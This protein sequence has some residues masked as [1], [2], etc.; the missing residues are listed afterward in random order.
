MRRY[1]VHTI[2]VAILYVLVNTMTVY[3]ACAWVLWWD[4][5]TSSNSYRTADARVPGGNIDIKKA[6]S[7]NILDTFTTETE[8]RSSLTSKIDG[9]LKNW[10]KE[11]A[12]AKAGT[13]TIDQ[14]GSNIIRKRSEY[15]GEHTSTHS[16]SLRYLCMPDTIDPRTLKGK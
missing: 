15:V 5:Q 9:M 3:A 7:W 14:V 8:C 10:Q 12:E 11:K 16:M 13:H 2:T 4:E 1:P 6:Q